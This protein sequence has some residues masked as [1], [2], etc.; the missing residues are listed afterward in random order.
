[1][2]LKCL[3]RRKYNW[4]MGAVY[5]PWGGFTAVS[6]VSKFQLPWEQPYGQIAIFGISS[7]ILWSWEVEA[8]RS[9]GINRCLCSVGGDGYGCHKMWVTIENGDQSPC[10]RGHIQ[11]MFLIGILLQSVV[12]NNHVI[13]GNIEVWMTCVNHAWATHAENR[14]VR[15]LEWCKTSWNWLFSF[16]LKC[17]NVQK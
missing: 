10:H 6:T 8:W 5:I 16:Q 4:E 1:M 15:I 11:V 12:S 9:H 14:L 3:I 7:C 2:C 17:I 13:S